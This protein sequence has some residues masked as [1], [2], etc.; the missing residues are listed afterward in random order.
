MAAA[1]ARRLGPDYKMAVTDRRVTDAQVEEWR[2][3]GSVHVEG[4]L[5]PEEVKA[6][7]VNMA[8]HF[9]AREEF[10]AHPDRRPRLTNGLAFRTLPF[11]GDTM[12]ANTFHPA[13]LDA[14]ERMIGT[15][16]LRLAQSLV[17]ASYATDDT[18][19]QLLHRDFHNNSLLTPHRDLTQFGHVPV[20]LYYTDVAIG[21]A[22]TYVAPYAAADAVPVLPTHVP[23]ESAPDLYAQERPVLARAGDAFFY[24]MRTLHRGS[25]F[26][27]PT[28]YRF[29]HHLAYRAAG[30][31][32]MSFTAW[33]L[34]M[35]SP[36]G[37]RC[38][39]QLDPRQRELLGIP[40]PGH[41]YWTDETVAYF[42]LRYPEADASPYRDAIAR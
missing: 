38:I 18:V 35:D 33:T 21:D 32:W 11:N 42:E 37:R 24:S 15:P 30:N 26:T 39:E 9:P 4:L 31:D 12:N 13:V 14:V 5:T 41:P 40:A 10:D 8:E 16:D 19:D 6:A 7:H 20:I 36:Q 2:T 29:V 25:A 27:D 17:R 28:G 23:K 34:P 1:P 22:P 3:N